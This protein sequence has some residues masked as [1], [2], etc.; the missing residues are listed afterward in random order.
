MWKLPVLK[1]VQFHK[2]KNVSRS[3]IY[4]II[5][6]SQQHEAL[7]TK[8]ITAYTGIYYLLVFKISFGNHS[9]MDS[10][11]N[12]DTLC[13]D[14]CVTGDRS[15]L[16]ACTCTCCTM[17]VHAHCTSVRTGCAKGDKTRNLRKKQVSKLITHYTGGFLLPEVIK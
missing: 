12:N 10:E 13:S 11:I 7:C 4:K 5:L 14:T 2:M 6:F 15:G 3:T 8:F 16:L 9:V 1:T 17:Y